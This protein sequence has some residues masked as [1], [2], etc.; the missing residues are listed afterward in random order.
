MHFVFRTHEDIKLGAG[1]Q[2]AKARFDLIIH[3]SNSVSSNL[4]I[5]TALASHLAQ[6][7][8]RLDETNL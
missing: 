8:T 2:K 3:L 1:Y 7:I 4:Q 6:N 5:A